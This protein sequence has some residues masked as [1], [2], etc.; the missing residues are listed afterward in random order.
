MVWTSFHLHIGN[1]HTFFGEVPKSLACFFFFNWGLPGGSVVTSPPARSLVWEDPTCCRA[2]KPMHHNHWLCPEPGSRNYW[3]PSALEPELFDER[4]HCNEKPTSC[5]SEQPPFSATRESPQAATKAQH[6]QINTF[7]K[8]SCLSYYG[9]GSILYTFWV[10]VLRL[11]YVWQ[12]CMPPSLWMK[13]HSFIVSFEEK[14]FLLIKS[15]LSI[16]SLHGSCSWCPVDLSYLVSFAHH[17][18]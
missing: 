3:S 12:I 13:S 11:I 5:N 17:C 1:S 2:T 15:S 9:V 6:R 8:L 7:L 14:L 10:Q 16:V 18:S 4:N